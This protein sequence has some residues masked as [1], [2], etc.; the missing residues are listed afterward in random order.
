M[1]YSQRVW[2]MAFVCGGVLAQAAPASGELVEEQKLI[3]S[4]GATSDEFANAVALGPGML[5]VGAPASRERRT[6]AVYAYRYR[7][8]AAGWVE[9]QKLVPSD[10][11]DQAEFGASLAID[12]DLALVGAPRSYE[13][14]LNA[15]AATIFR[16]DGSSWVKEQ[17]LVASDPG[18]LHLFGASVALADAVAVVG[19]PG[20]ATSAGAVYVFRRQGGSWV[21]VQKLV[22][23][24]AAAWRHFGTSVALSDDSQVILAGAPASYSSSVDPGS[25]YAFRLVGSSYIEE[26]KIG[27]RDG[28]PN[29]GFGCSVAIDET[30]A[31]IGARYDDDGGENSGSA[32]V[33]RY[34]AAA[35]LWVEQ[36]KLRPAD[37]RARAT[38]AS[39]VSLKEGRALIGAPFDEHGSGSAYLYE[40]DGTSWVEGPKVKSH[41]WDFDDHFAH[42]VAIGEHL[43][44]VGAVLDEKAG[45]P[46]VGSA[47]VFSSEARSHD[48]IPDARELAPD[49][50]RTWYV[51][52][53]GDHFDEIQH[54]INAA[55]P[56]DVILVRPARYYPSFLVTKGVTIRSTSGQFLLENNGL[57]AVERVPAG[58][59]ASIS[60]LQVAVWGGYTSI[61]IRDCAGEVVLEDVRVAGDIWSDSGD[62]ALLHTS[63]CNLVS[64]TCVRIVGGQSW[65]CYS[66]PPW[67]MAIDSAR[68]LLHDAAVEGWSAAGACPGRDGPGGGGGLFLADDSSVVLSLPFI[69][70]GRGANGSDHDP[71]GG[72]PSTRGGPGGSALQALLDSRDLLVMGRGG[73][74]VRGGDG[75]NGGRDYSGSYYRER[76]GDG[77]IGLTGGLVEVSQVELSGGKGGYGNPPGGDGNPYV[78]DVAFTDPPY[79]TLD[80]PGDLRPGAH[81]NVSIEGEPGARVTLILSNRRGWTELPGIPGPPLVVQPGDFFMALDAGVIGPT[82]RLEIPIALLD[83]RAIRGLILT[84]QAMV[85]RETVFVL[86]NAA[87]RVVGE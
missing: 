69:C 55:I 22:V 2:L 15:G 76:G 53:P 1:S 39:C 86:T 17:K 3:P 23:S 46:Y 78:G 32:Y 13:S 83:D 8:A 4:D 65:D 85:T 27:A 31:L 7:N 37:A 58:E 11:G 54:A 10:G 49:R 87:T 68:V 48:V 80:F 82:G 25:A 5:L 74:E 56:G 18:S 28:A 14:G 41:D 59:T 24:D 33:V 50:N 9:I 70:G 36:Q 34:D 51:G 44:V 75:G 19:A 62:S 45:L 61:E 72:Y 12:R 43:A 52:G 77:G 6:G 35:Q 20:A 66:V 57:A 40:F 63:N 38:F 71:W 29:D 79:P 21:Q 73:D 26:Q 64:M 47:Y 16:F 42:S 30:T 60:G 81:F 84:A 67:A